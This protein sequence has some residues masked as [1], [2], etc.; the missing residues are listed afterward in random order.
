MEDIRK[1]YKGY[2]LSMVA[3]RKPGTFSAKNGIQKGKGSDLGAEPARINIFLLPPPP[4]PP[5]ARLR[6]SVLKGTVS[7]YF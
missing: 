2:H 1:A 3:I 6:D 5:P 7:R 4:P